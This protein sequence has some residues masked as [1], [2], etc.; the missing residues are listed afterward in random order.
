VLIVRYRKLCGYYNI[1]PCPFDDTGNEKPGR[2]YN[3]SLSA[4]HCNTSQISEVKYQPPSF[5][6]EPPTTQD[7]RK[8]TE[9][10]QRVSFGSGVDFKGRRRAPGAE[11][12]Y[13]RSHRGGRSD[14]HHKPP[15]TVLRIF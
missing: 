9:I 4:V 6:G 8:R 2:Y 10:V 13:A 15:Q 12:S 11:Y 3:L 14:R 7:L 1:T 5:E